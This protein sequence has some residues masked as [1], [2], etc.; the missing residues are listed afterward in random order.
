MGINEELKEIKESMAKI[1]RVEELRKEKK[2]KKFKIPFTKRVGKAQEKQNYVTV[3]KINENGSLDFSK[4]KIEDQTFMENGVPRLGTP[5]YVLRYKK[6][7][8]VILP[9]WSVKPYSPSE[10]YAESLNNGSNTKGYAIL[11][12]RMLNE[13]VG[14]KK[15][16]GGMVKWIIGL[17]F[18]AIIG[19]ALITGGGM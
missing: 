13:Q 9:S 5:D 3:I 8:V 17:G 12:A 1:T 14:A 6:N 11:M 19:Y 7:P 16:I 10:Q 15:Q 18:A 2:T 4:K